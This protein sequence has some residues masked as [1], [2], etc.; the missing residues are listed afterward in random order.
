MT[1][2]MP[3]PAYRRLSDLQSGIDNWYSADQLKEAYNAGLEDAAILCDNKAQ[4][5]FSSGCAVWSDYFARAISK[6][7]EQANDR[8]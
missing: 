8:T 3:E 6:L 1:F 5:T 2:K 4:K 7:K